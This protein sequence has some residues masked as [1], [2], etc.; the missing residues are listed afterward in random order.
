MSTWDLLRDLPLE[1]EAVEPEMLARATPRFTRKTT[2][3]HLSGGGEEG[4][5]EDVTYDGD[6]HERWPQLA[7]E[8]S[9][10]LE[11]FSEQVGAIDLFAAEPSQHAYF[12]Y[13]RWAIESAA[14]DLA[15]RQAGTALG[16][17]LGR[18]AA[19][20]RFVSSNGALGGVARALPGAAL[21]A[22]PHAGVDRRPV[23]RARRARHRR[24]RR[25]EGRLQG[26]HR[27][28][29]GRSG[30]LRTR[31]RRVPRSW[32]EDPDLTPETDALLEPHRDRVTWDA[33]IHS[34]ADVEALPFAP[35]CLNCKPSRFGALPRLFEFYDRC[36]EQEIAL[37][38]GGQFELGVGRAQIQL[39]AALFHPDGWND[40]AP[41]R[42]QR[43]RSHGRDCP[44]AR[45]HSCSSRASARTSPNNS[46]APADRRA[47]AT[48]ANNGIPPPSRSLVHL[49]RR[50]LPTTANRPRQTVRADERM[51]G[52]IARGRTKSCSFVTPEL[53]CL[54]PQ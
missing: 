13:R 43:S 40:V 3:V 51:L 5:G 8:G 37:Y 20:V 34:W 1:I 22:R 28:Q 35:R 52:A 30:A 49:S 32:I 33:P 25:P 42:V 21:Q 19:P 50:G 44:P 46:G 41:G 15:L 11:S 29:P 26:H 48:P 2:V 47:G 23:R 24:G 12:D 53:R 54:A 10:T 38:G 31:S 9:W 17:V 36:A 16:A 7:L 14:L 18:E 39:L 27:R 4:L 45:S 6:E